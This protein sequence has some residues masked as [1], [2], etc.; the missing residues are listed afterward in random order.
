MNKSLPYPLMAEALAL[1]VVAFAA[2]TIPARH[3]ARVDPL[4]ALRGE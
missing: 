4:I 1:A 2:T 3:A